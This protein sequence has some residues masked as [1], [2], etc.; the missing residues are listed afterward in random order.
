MEFELPLEH[1]DLFWFARDSFYTGI[2]SAIIICA[3]FNSQTYYYLEDQFC[4]FPTLMNVCTLIWQRE[5]R[6]TLLLP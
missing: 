2:S 4:G 3:P 5:E 6:A 1:G